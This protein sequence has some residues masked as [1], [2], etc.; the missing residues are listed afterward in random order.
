MRR[1]HAL[2]RATLVGKEPTRAHPPGRVALVMVLDRGHRRYMVNPALMTLIR[3]CW[4]NGSSFVFSDRNAPGRVA[5]VAGDVEHSLV[6][7]P[8]I[9]AAGGAETQAAAGSAVPAD[10][11]DDEPEHVRP[12]VA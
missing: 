11:A 1:A 3:F 4:F 7:A 12:P 9:T 5:L 2:L 8:V 6:G 10:V